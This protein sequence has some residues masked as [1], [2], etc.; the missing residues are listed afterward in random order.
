MS[1]R[2]SGLRAIVA[3]LRR[4]AVQAAHWR[5]Y[6][7]KC[8]DS[9]MSE[10]AAPIVIAS[11]AKQSR[12]PR[13]ALDRFVAY[14][15]RDDGGNGLLRKREPFRPNRQGSSTALVMPMRTPVTTSTSA[16]RANSSIG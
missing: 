4:F 16:G 14:A 6:G 12:V 3:E 9:L 1:L 7:A 15:P 13:V 8:D 5:A 2:P 10:T 11:A